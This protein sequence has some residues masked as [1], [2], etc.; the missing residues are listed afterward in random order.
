MLYTSDDIQDMLDSCK[1]NV[2]LK[3]AVI[4]HFTGRDKGAISDVLDD[5]YYER[6]DRYDSD[7]CEQFIK[8]YEKEAK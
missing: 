6:F 5:G 2:K 3:E 8:A 7:I 1:K 4:S